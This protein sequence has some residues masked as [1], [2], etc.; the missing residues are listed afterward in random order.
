MLTT[1]QAGGREATRL[2]LCLTVDHWANDRSMEPAKLE[3]ACQLRHAETTSRAQ[4]RECR[5][6]P[7]RT[8]GA[9]QWRDQ[10]IIE[11]I[12]MYIS[13][14]RP[15]SAGSGRRADG[16]H[17][18][19]AMRKQAHS[20][21]RRPRLGLLSLLSPIYTECWQMPDSFPRYVQNAVLTHPPVTATQ[22]TNNEF[23]NMH[24]PGKRLRAIATS[25]SRES[26]RNNP[27]PTLSFEWRC[28]TVQLLH[29][30]NGPRS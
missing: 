25:H 20:N 9:V 19:R 24:V 29:C 10:S 12:P 16:G 17:G 28:V 21:A 15:N 7:D 8:D 14:E 4:W 6:G 11:T 5:S 26:L 23:M 13:T 1:M 3:L 22:G 27:F 2:A 30:G 18:T